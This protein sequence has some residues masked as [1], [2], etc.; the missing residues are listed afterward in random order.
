V[1]SDHFFHQ[2]IIDTTNR[3]WCMRQ[4]VHSAIDG[5]AHSLQIR[6]VGKHQ[7]RMP[8]ALGN[9]RSRDI[10]RQMSDVVRGEV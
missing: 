2:S 4:N 9:S 5:D 6:G 10:Q 7:L 8:V 3:V 1:A